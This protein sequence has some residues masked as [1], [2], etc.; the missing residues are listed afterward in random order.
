MSN[1]GINVSNW[2][3]T[4]IAAPPLNTRVPLY[5]NASY[6]SL[7]NNNNCSGCSMGI[8]FDGSASSN[9]VTN[10][11]VSGVANHGIY[12]SGGNN[13]SWVI[14][15][16]NASNCLGWAIYY[17]FG[18]PASVNNNT[19]TGSVNGWFLNSAT[20]FTMT[21]PTGIGP[22]KNIYGGHTG[23]VL[24]LLEFPQFFN[25]NQSGVENCW[26]V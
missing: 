7:F 3:F 6:N 17:N 1:N 9:T 10:N 11:N 2:N 24:Y 13:Q 16:N 14:D 8:Q 22:N 19:L 25:Q 15:N 26:E 5:V 23:N 4:T 21:A 20:N 18:T 12:L